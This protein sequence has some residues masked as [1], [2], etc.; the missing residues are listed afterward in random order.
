MPGH[1]WAAPPDADFPVGDPG[2]YDE[3]PRRG[4]RFPV[5]LAVVVVV[6]AVL[7]GLV[8]WHFVGQHGTSPQASATGHPSGG[9]KQASGGATSGA[10]GSSGPS[11]PA[12]TP[13]SNTVVLG[14]AVANQATAGSVAAF[15]TQYFAAIN[16][17][18]Y[19]AY[20]SLF[21]PGARPAGTAKQF[22]A[23][24]RTTSDS[25]ATLVG[26]STTANGESAASLTF[27]SRQDP[28]DSPT[29]TACTS[30]AVT[31]YLV[32]SGTSYLIGNPPASYHAS[33][34]PCP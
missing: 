19:Q 6:A 8:A 12:A 33:F 18:D 28:A 15:L 17:R 13:G 10:T 2:I 20:I 23:G 9:G 34:R 11:T 26:L 22:N 27:T 32:P 5:W 21:A 16:T 24:Y 30:W 29:H 25:G 7:G 1:A 31:F 14:P 4:R 3:P